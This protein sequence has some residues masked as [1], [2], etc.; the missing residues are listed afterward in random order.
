MRKGVGLFILI[1]FITRVVSNCHVNIPKRD[2]AT[3]LVATH[4]TWDAIS[5]GQIRT[6]CS[7]C[8]RRDHPETLL[9]K[10]I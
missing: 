9:K 3:H 5:F 6:L 7:E 8:P 4:A 2:G 1:L 10:T